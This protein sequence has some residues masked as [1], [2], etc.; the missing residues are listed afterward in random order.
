V[1][2][3]TSLILA[4]ALGLCAAPEE[5]WAH[6][7]GGAKRSGGAK[8]AGVHHFHRFHHRPFHRAFFFGYP[9][10]YSRPYYPYW[11][12]APGAEYPVY[13][14]QFPGEPTPQTTDLVFCPSR[15]AYYPD[16]TDCPGGWARVIP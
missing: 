12:P 15:G 8:P 1:T 4:A 11:A 9:G 3:C 5:A 13:I 14:E 7:G 2:A 16:A 10:V 6:K